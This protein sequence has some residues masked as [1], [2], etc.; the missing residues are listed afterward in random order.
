MYQSIEARMYVGISAEQVCRYDA[1]L[2]T[3]G[4]KIFGVV[5]STIFPLTWL[6]SPI[7]GCLLQPPSLPPLTKGISPFRPAAPP[8]RR[9]KGPSSY[10]LFG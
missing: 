7:S 2:N 6:A 10:A 9:L 3:A 4:Y 5:G 8:I 1:G